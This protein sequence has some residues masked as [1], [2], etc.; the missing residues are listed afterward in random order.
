M[1]QRSVCVCVT[2]SLGPT[3]AVYNVWACMSVCAFGGSF[4]EFEYV[5]L[6]PSSASPPFFYFGRLMVRNIFQIW[7]IAVGKWHQHCKNEVPRR[8]IDGPANR[9]FIRRNN[10]LAD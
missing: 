7:Q 6:G 3:K 9:Q 5:I 4:I 2:P 1:S 10:L 8:R